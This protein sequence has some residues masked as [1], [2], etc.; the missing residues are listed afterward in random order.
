M[1]HLKGIIGTLVAL[2]VLVVLALLPGGHKE[3]FSVAE[4]FTL[5]PIIE[6][7]TIG[8]FDL[9]INNA[10]VYLWITTAVV[11][12]GDLSRLRIE[13]SV[14]ERYVGSLRIGLP[15]LLSFES[16]PGETFAA[17][18]VEISPVLDSGSRTNPISLELDSP[19]SKIKAGMYASIRL[20]TRESRG[21]IRIPREA[22]IISNSGTS[23]FVVDDSNTAHRRTIE[24]GLQG[25]D[26][27]EVVSGLE[28]GEIVVTQGQTLLSEGSPVHIVE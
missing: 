22:V 16:Y 9:S 17:H 27:V 24:L 11:V 6:L 10:V 14:A 3:E 13:T 5:H 1:K 2:A 28:P 18:V 23:V 7:P 4:E 25:E 8:P 15:A 20:I 12:V 26:M 19:A 21:T